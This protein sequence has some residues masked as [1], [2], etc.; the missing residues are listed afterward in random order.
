MIQFKNNLTLI[1]ETKTIAI[2]IF[3]NQKHAFFTQ[4]DEALD[5]QLSTL[6][7]QNVISTKFKDITPIYTLG[8]IK[9]QKIL[10]VG[11]GNYEDFTHDKYRQVLGT[12]TKNAL[13]DLIISIETFKFKDIS[14]NELA[15]LAAEA[16]TLSTYTFEG[17]KTE[18][19]TSKSLTFSLY[20]ETDI[21][22]AIERG[23]IYGTATNHARDLYNEPGNKLTATE[24]A[25][26]IAT[27]SK[28][29]NLECRIIEKDEME[30]LNMGGLLGVNRGST[31]PPKMIVVTYQGTST[32]E[33][34][35]ALVGK[36][37]T[38]DT[39]GYCLKPR[40][41][42]NG[43]QGDMG[44][45]ASAFGAFEIAVRLKLPVN[46]LLVIPSTDNMI[47]ADS[48]KPGDILH[49]MNGKTV[50]VTNTDAEGR[51]IL[52]DAITLAKTLGASRIID[53]ATLTGA[54]IVALGSD[55]TG[56]FSNDQDFFNQFKKASDCSNEDIWQ[57]PLFPRDQL[58]L[59]TSLTADLNNS[60]VGKPGAIMAA[61]FLN[62]FVGETPWIHLDIAGTSETKAAHDLGPKGA[63]G[64][65]V[66]TIA[67]YLETNA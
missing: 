4:L 17:Y 65:M 44:G 38:Y 30:T 64:A 46:L 37:L 41:S 57:M 51:L 45:A 13:E 63:T 56:T 1:S 21:S 42:M 23:I 19:A 61:A 12:L 26:R 10:V 43:M 60:P 20:S 34:V 59:R 27:F 53:L 22:S 66:R 49:M 29:H 40:T 15:S 58:A 18:E 54:I 31:E 50:E 62:E 39:G 16:I 2:G 55:T 11:L 9:S 48:I 6:L 5:K 7:E 3:S 14:L 8:K 24:L 35:T 67:H 33:N 28:E 52:A 25:N 32:F 36:G 47:S